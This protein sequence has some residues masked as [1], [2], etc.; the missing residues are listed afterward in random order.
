MQQMPLSASISAPASIAN[1][2]L[3]GSLTTDAVRPAAVDALPL[4]YT[5]RGR[6][7]A[8]YLSSWLLAVDGSPMMATLMS[9]R[10]DV[11]SSVRLCTPPNS[12]SRIACLIASWPYTE[13]HTERARS[14]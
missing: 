10:S 2:L 8:T 12:I 3:S 9:P 6:K 11:P 4:A 5:A 14:E 7:P 13:G 1:S